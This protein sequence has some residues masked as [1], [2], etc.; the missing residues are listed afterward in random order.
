MVPFQPEMVDY[1]PKCPGSGNARGGN[2]SY[3]AQLAAFYPKLKLLT[4]VASDFLKRL[5]S[6]TCKHEM[7][8]T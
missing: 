8:T 3:L 1:K 4:S 7:K 5:N 2:T 6:I